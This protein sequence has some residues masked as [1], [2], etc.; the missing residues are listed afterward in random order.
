VDEAVFYAY[1][2]PEPS[3]L[4]E[5]LVEPSGARYRGELGEFVLPYDEVRRAP[6]PEAALAAFL[7]STYRA[8]ASRAGWPM[9][10]LDHDTLKNRPLPA[11]AESHR[12]PEETLETHLRLVGAHRFEE[13]IARSYADGCVVLTADG[14]YRGPS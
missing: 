7:D 10:S 12:T 9:D 1:A 11:R 14:V 6:D 4:R 5:Q 13:D 2:V 3:G 8:A